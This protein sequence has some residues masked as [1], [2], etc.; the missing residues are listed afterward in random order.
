MINTD[1]NKVKDFFKDSH[2]SIVIDK[3]RK[4]LLLK[5]A[6]KITTNYIY[7]NNQVNINFICT[8][9]SRRS[10]ICQVW[11]FFAAN[12][13]NLH[14]NALSGG[15][16]V[17]AFHRNTVKA[18]TDVGFNFTLEKIS[19]TN[20]TYKISY[21]ES[22]KKLLGFSKIYNNQ[23]NKT[24]YFVLTTCNN[25]DENCPFIPEAINRFHLPYTDP[26]HSDGSTIQQVTYLKTNKVIAAEIY[27][28]F[29]EVKNLL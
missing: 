15:I 11:S 10:Q 18:L 5:I 24:P 20:P 17:T 21:D 2:Q 28:L 3:S 4:K 22:Q 8:H 12:Y 25:A 19:H 9:N 14:I 1:P 29:N 16:E 23:E 7:N 27:F 6:E 13:F 26:K